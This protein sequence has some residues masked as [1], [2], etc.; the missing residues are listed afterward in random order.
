MR[1][2]K[3]KLQI[4]GFTLFQSLFA[5]PSARVWLRKGTNYGILDPFIEVSG[6]P[7]GSGLVVAL[8]IPGSLGA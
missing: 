8:C 2:R 7:D 1:K 4:L 5:V 6:N 3:G